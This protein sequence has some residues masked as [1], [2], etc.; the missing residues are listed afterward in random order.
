MQER[1]T[2]DRVSIWLHWTMAILIIALFATGWIWGIFERGSPPRM[3][4]FRA[5]IVLGSTVLALAVFRIGWRLT[6]P[7]PPLPAG[8]NRPTVIAARATHGLLYLAILIQPILGL[9]TI[10]A[11][12]KTLGRWPRDLHVTLTG[13]IFAIIV[14]HAAAAL[15]HQFIRRDGLL[16][17]MLPSSLATIVLT[18]AMIC[19]PEANAQVI[20]TDVLGRQVRL[21]QPAQRIAIDDGRYLIA[22]SLIAPDPVSLLSAW[23]RDIN[24]IGPAV[25]E[26]YRQTFPAIETLHQIASS[27][28][29][30]SVEQVLAAE[31][32]LAIFS[33]TSQPSEEQIRQIEAGGVPVAIIDFFNQPLQ[34]LEPS[35]RFL[36]QVTGR[37]EQ[38]E[39]FIAFRS[40]RAHA[41]T[42]ALAASTGERPR[43]F[44]EPHAART[45]ECCASPGTG[46]IGNYIEF[47][48][49]ENIGSAAIKGVTGV[50]SLEFVIEADPDVYIA[51]GGPHME[52]TNG[53]LIGPG[54]DR[55]RVH[56]TLERVAGRNGISS[57]KAVRE[58][59]VHGIAH[60]LLNSPLDV[61]TMEALAKWIRPDLFDGIDLDGTLHEINARFLAVP[62]EGI[63]W[64]D[65]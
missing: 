34:N 42:S 25:Y 5:H 58:G 37:T 8:M 3:Y 36:G 7:A 40:E 62:L 14:L 27:A 30:L 26:Q 54:Y 18:G 38:A 50:L 61:L 16:S 55:Q 2:Y 51:T 10:T 24:R 60:Q 65:L 47:A 41:I 45:D 21:E 4:L 17:R 33:L 31:P 53:L 1:H 23:P 49:G 39:D 59:H 32:D 9:L 28:G 35:L 46:N 20:A 56:D 15:W 12:G 52:G 64:M 13:V 44:L 48:G 63:N 29:N 57:L 43:V 11:F 6:H 22:L 19:S